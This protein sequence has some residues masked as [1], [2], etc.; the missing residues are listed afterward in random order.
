M[1]IASQPMM[2]SGAA[3]CAISVGID[4]RIT[5]ERPGVCDLFELRFDLLI[6]RLIERGA[7]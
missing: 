5:E 2:V 1:L 7:G 4:H 3:C 6:A